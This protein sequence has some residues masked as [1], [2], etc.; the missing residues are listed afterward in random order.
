[1]GPAAA[2]EEARDGVR[3]RV[4]MGDRERSGRWWRDNAATD[5]SVDLVSQTRSAK[6]AMALTSAK[7]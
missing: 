2:G 4:S 7:S 6:A 5:M 1:M 3:E